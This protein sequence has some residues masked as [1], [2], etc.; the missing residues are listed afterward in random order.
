MTG[1]ILAKSFGNMNS[2][3]IQKARLLFGEI[4]DVLAKYQISA[5]E[6]GLHSD[7]G[8]FVYTIGD[9]SNPTPTTATTLA[10]DI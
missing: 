10:A 6:L 8:G 7:D 1:A 4:E 9:I 5:A 2:G 3:D